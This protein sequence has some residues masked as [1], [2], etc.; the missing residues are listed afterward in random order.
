[1]TQTYVDPFLSLETEIIAYN[2]GDVDIDHVI[3]SLTDLVINGDIDEFDDPFAAC[4][5]LMADGY[6]DVTLI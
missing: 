6:I 2:R 1:M 5:Q 4:D 3:E